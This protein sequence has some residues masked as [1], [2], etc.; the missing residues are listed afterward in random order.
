LVNIA[1]E[2]SLTTGTASEKTS[3][4]T[5]DKIISFIKDDALITIERLAEYCGFTTRSIERNLNKL[6][7]RNKIKRVGPNKGAIGR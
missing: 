3:K 4:K 5:S 1:P 6:Q 7:K 2:G